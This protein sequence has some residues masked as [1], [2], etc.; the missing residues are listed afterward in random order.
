MMEEVDPEPEPE[1]RVVSEI[2]RANRWK[3]WD[4]IRFR[5]GSASGSGDVVGDVNAGSNV[6]PGAAPDAV[7]SGS[8]TEASSA[9][10][11]TKG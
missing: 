6:T 2:L 7:A 8:A 5:L 11:N 10:G 1:R 4:D 3:F 9:T